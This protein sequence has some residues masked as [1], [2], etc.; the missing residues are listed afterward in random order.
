MKGTVRENCSAVRQSRWLNVVCLLVLPLLDMTLMEW[1][2][3][4]S[5]SVEFWTQQFAPHAW[6]FLFGWLFLVFVYGVLCMAFGRHWPAQLILSVVCFGFGAATYLKLQMRGEPLLPW[7]FSQLGEF[8]GVASKVSL[9]I[10]WHFFA[11]GACFAVLCALSIWVKLPPF[12]RRGRL[13]AAGAALNLVLL[14][15]LCFGVL[16][17]QNVCEFFGIWPDMWM[18][19]RYYRNHG[20]VTGFVTN[21]RVLNITAPDGYSEEAV[22]Q[23]AEETQQAAA[24]RQPLFSGSYA[25]AVQESEQETQ[26]NI[27][28]LMNESFWDVTRLEGIEY[29]R[30]LTP[31]LNRL[32]QQAAYGYCFSPSYGGGT[33]DV[34]FEALTGFSLEHL[35]SGAKPYQQ[36]ATK[37]LPALPHF[38]KANGYETL[39]VH[40]YGRKF[41]SRDTAYPNLGIDT[42]I[43]QE[44]FVS[45]DTRR[46]FIS[47]HAMTQRIIEEYEARVED[48]PLFI[49]A[50]TMQNHT[51]YD[52]SR[53]PESELVEI[54]KHPGLSEETLS[55]LRDFATGVH[56]ADAALGELIDYFEQ[57]QEPVIVVFWGDHFN[58]VGQ[59]SE[60]YEKTGFIEPGDTSTMHL[61]QTD[62]LIWSN[63][64]NTSV[65]LGTIAAYE[66]SPVMMDLYG[67]DMPLWFEKL[68]SELPIL[69]ARTRGVTVE[70]DSSLSE[71]MTPQQEALFQ[72]NWLIQYDLMFGKGYWPTQGDMP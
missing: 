30:E 55:Q 51:T 34:E 32:K 24:Q 2:H 44:D 1:V 41:W 14:G 68:A 23:L 5:F 33:C 15:A 47:D 29:D 26:P 27:I 52:E 59:G 46:G 20:I 16:L 35:P 48:G 8:F 58:P 49:H 56:E 25:L 64:Y 36:Y 53:Y 42:F 21:L 70:P 71:S 38:L 45:P 67:L 17:Q 72:E 40:G 12:A 11:A 66:I 65:E 62:L 7:D 50:V 22:Q 19:D 69:R 6:S 43:A 18:Q 3:R 9:S 60:L 61:R 39:A 4:G 54:V 31:N 57:R 37:P 10:P 28:Y 13:R 63:Y